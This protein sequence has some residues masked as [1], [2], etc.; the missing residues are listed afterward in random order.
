[1]SVLGQRRVALES[2]PSTQAEAQRLAAEG[3]PHGTLVTAS[4]QTAGRGRSG[5]PWVSEGGGLYLS[6]VL[7]P[8]LPLERWPRLTLLA[9]AAL[10]EA[11]RGLGADAFSKWPNDVVVPGAPAGPLG[12]YRKV[13]GILCEAH[14]S[15]RGVEGAVL[16][17]GLN[18]RPPPAGFGA[19][20]ALVAG[21][22]QDLALSPERALEAVLQALERRL[23]AP[24]DDE[25]FARALALLRERSATLGRQVQ[26]RDQGL[27]GGAEDLDEDGALLL[28]TPDG[29]RVRVVAGDVWPLSSPA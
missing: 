25:A 9:G 22:L 13:A 19:E 20:L 21:S 11:L 2:C 23:A 12:P 8:E 16:G 4:R 3:A 10:V 7:R 24:D 17:V 1:M 27:A 26:V 15:A 29:Q 28:R 14:T 6:L 18:L 5:R